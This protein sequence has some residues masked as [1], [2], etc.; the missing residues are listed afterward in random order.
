MLQKG[1]QVYVRSHTGYTQL[2]KVL[3]TCINNAKKQLQSFWAIMAYALLFQ[4]FSG[5]IEIIA[6]KYADH[7][8]ECALFWVVSIPGDGKTEGGY[9]TTL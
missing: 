9:M 3:R 5:Y 8:G 6:N 4:N 7:Q 1:L 2:R